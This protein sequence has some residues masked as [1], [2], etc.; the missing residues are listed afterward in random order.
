VVAVEPVEA[1]FFTQD[2]V[3]AL[4]RDMPGLD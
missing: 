1:V 3:R 4:R 2:Q